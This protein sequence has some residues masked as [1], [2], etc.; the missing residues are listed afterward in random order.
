MTPPGVIEVS[1]A[2]YDRHAVYRPD[3]QQQSPTFFSG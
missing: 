2:S 3:Y 1:A